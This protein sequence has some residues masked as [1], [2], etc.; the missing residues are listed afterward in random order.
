MKSSADRNDHPSLEARS[1]TGGTSMLIQE[2][3]GLPTIFFEL[4][5]VT[6]LACWSS[7]ALSHNNS[8]EQFRVVKCG[9]NG[10][11]EVLSCYHLSVY[12]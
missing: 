5:K 11:K 4:E 3:C 2:R 8:H 10:K 12:R 9:E 6:T 1:K 7:S